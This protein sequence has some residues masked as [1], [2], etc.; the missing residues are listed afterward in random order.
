[1][2]KGLKRARGFRRDRGCWLVLEIYRFFFFVLT[3]FHHRKCF[4]NGTKTS[5]RRAAISPKPANIS[6]DL[7][8]SA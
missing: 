3:L 6:R 5:A 8:S 4:G 1:M 7:A 2:M